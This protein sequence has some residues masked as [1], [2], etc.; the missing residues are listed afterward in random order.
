MKRLFFILFAL[1]AILVAVVL[2][3]P[4]FIPVSTY[5]ATIETQASQ[6]LGRQV[7]IGDD[8][9]IKI[10]PYTAFKVTELEV[11]NADGF[12]APFLVRVEKAEI[13]VKLFKLLFNREV[14]IDQFVLTAPEINLERKRSGAANWEIGSSPSTSDSGS[15]N[16]QSSDLNDL[17]L[18]DVR[19][20][21]GKIRF[22]DGAA[23]KTYALDDVDVDVTLDKLDAPLTAKG[24]FLFDGTPSQ[25]NLVMTSPR[26]FL[27]R[28]A[29][30]IKL[31]AK[32]GDTE[33]GGD[34]SVGFEGDVMT[35][36]GPADFNAPDLPAF[37]ALMGSPLPEAPGFDRLMVRGTL[38]GN[39]NIVDLKGAKIL[40]DS[41]EAGGDL[42]LALNRSRPKATGT[43]TASTLDLRPY[44]PPP[45]TA[46]E[47]FPAWSDAEL[48]FTSLR[49][50]DADLDISTDQILLNGM[51]I[52][53]S[54]MNLVI[55]N[56]RM[57]AEIPEMAMYQG[58]GSGRL[59]VNARS[60]TPSMSGNFKMGKVA[61]EAFC[62]DVLNISNILGLG[63]F[64]VN[65][66]ASGSSQAAIMQTLDGGGGF[67]VV[68]GALK[69]INIAELARS[70]TDLRQGVNPA[71]IT[72]LVSA[73]QAP[74]QQTDF[75]SFL[76]NFTIENGIMRAPQ[77][78]MTSPVLSMLGTGTID[79]PRQVLDIRL[80]P[81]ANINTDGSGGQGVA[82]PLQITGTFSNPKVGIDAAAL[83][84]GQAG[85][86]L[87]G[88]IG[89]ALGDDAQDSPVG[90]ILDGI[91]DGATG[92]RDSDGNLIQKNEAS[93]EDPEEQLGRAA[94]GALGSILGRRKKAEDDNGEKEDEDTP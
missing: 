4:Q 28:S 70:A 38:G 61:A 5:K 92:E 41:I 71:A 60:R 10:I 74:S 23:D 94:A 77:I 29:T 40:F 90:G 26:A 30:N 43:L 33:L 35:L 50:M 12:S 56:G 72:G 73:A 75:T 79:L 22:I 44:M 83:L 48:D 37:A 66:S 14:E 6:S 51:S 31:S 81:R 82:V 16:V 84:R 59:V 1:I 17:R 46:P 67:D 58:A 57:V 19:V 24:S 55:E 36:S 21:D 49:N 87:R 54:E 88:I 7:T 9:S 34:V 42:K 68:E 80:N 85:G 69:G 91:L 39:T 53:R 25:L 47:G 89:G 78:E 2:V 62:K 18:G 11:S 52:G 20:V 15:N 8:L 13:G 63:G 76:S 27:N 32:L 65:F 3:V 64:N 45:E 86:Q 93:N